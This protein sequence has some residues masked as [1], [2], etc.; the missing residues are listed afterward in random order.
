MCLANRVCPCGITYTP[1]NNRQQFCSE[2]HAQR[3]RDARRGKSKALS[4]DEIPSL[5]HRRAFTH[6]S[7]VSYKSHRP[8]L[9]GEVGEIFCVTCGR[10]LGR[11]RDGEYEGAGYVQNGKVSCPF[12]S[13]VNGDGSRVLTPLSYALPSASK[14]LLPEDVPPRR[15]AYEWDLLRDSDGAAIAAVCIEAG[16][17]AAAP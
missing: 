8:L 5:L 13:C 10:F 3:A 11:V 12:L 17:L 7:Y 16:Q 15:Y 4:V 1:S 6:L 14:P 2:A 9:K